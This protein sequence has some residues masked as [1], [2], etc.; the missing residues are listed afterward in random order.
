MLIIFSG[1][2]ATGKTTIS[3][4]LARQIDGMHLRIDSIE[5]ALRNEGLQVSV[6]GYVAAYAVA[7]DNL[8][9][10]RLVVADSVNPWPLTRKA[11]R[12]VA[13]RAGTVAVDVEVVCSDRGEHRRR[14][15]ERRPDI[16]GHRVPTWDEI[17]S[18]DYR[19][20]DEPR[21]RIDTAVMSIEE[22]VRAIRDTIRV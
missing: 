7:E 2:S 15:E 14:A 3:R 1:L 17:V 18:R 9:L 13:E 11:W 8:R 21:V 12:A 4:E 20:W 5:Q 10:G 16:P 19:P 22:A 6:E